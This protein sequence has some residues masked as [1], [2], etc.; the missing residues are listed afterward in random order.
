MNI[1]LPQILLTCLFVICSMSCTKGQTPIQVAGTATKTAVQ[2]GNWNDPATWGG[3]LPG[4][5]A[6][7]L[8]PSGITI[9]VNS[10]ISE[11]MKSIRIANGA[12]LQYATS[13]NT[14]LRTEYLVSEMGG[15]FEIGTASNKIAPN[16]KARLVFAE[17]GGTTQAEDP[18]R[19]APG[20]VLM[21][22]VR[23][24]GA[25][26]TNWLA[27]NNANQPSQ[28]AT[29]LVL[30]SAP[31]GWQV[32]DK[33]ALAG[34]D[35]NSFTSDEVVEI[36]GISGNV[37][38]IKS[39]LQLDHKAP[40][41]AS[42]LD[43]H[44]ANISRNIVVT[45]ENPSVT[46]ISGDFRKPRG[47]MMFMHNQD[48]DL[49]YV[50]ANNTGR[51]D[52]S[53]ILDDWD[54]EDLSRGR[55]TGN[56]IANGGRNPRGRYSFHF[57]RGAVDTSVYPAKAFLP[58]PAHVEGCVVNNDPGWG[59][60][61]HSSRVN[62]VRNVSYDVIGS[63]FCTESGN[64]TGSFIENIAIR[65]Y[66]PAEPMTAIPRPRN[67]YFDG[68]PTQALADIR[69][70]RQDFAWQGD[71]FWF[72]GTGVTVEGNVVAGST[73]H[74]YVYWVDGLIEKG[75]GMARGDIDTHVPA[76]E[77]PVLNQALKDWKAQYPGFVLDIWYL[78]PRP[79]KNNTAYTFARGVHTYYVHT[80]FHL[81][82]E[83][84]NDPEEWMN[85]TPDIYRKQL[86][87]VFD[88]TILWNIRRRGFG[89]NHT[90]NVTIQNSRVVGYNA[91]GEFENYGTNP[92]PGVIAEEPVAIGMDLDFYHNTYNWTL[93]NNTIEG[94]SG[95]AVG[96]TT[97]LNG[98]VIIDGGTFNNSGTDIEIKNPTHEPNE[99]FPLVFDGNP[100]VTIKEEAGPIRFLNENK[101]IVLLPQLHNH[102]FD[103][104]GFA[105][106]AD[107]KEGD[108]YF[109]PHELTFN[110]GPFINSRVYYNAQDSDFIPITS[111]TQCTLG[112][113]S[114]D[115]IPNRFVGKTNTQL[116]SQNNGKSFA[117]SITPDNA[118]PHTQIVG[119]KATGVTI[120]GCPLDN[121]QTNNFN[122]VVNNETCK[123]RSNGE[124]LITS[125]N[126]EVY[127]VNIGGSTH[128][129]SKEFK[130]GN[131]A[132]GTHMLCIGVRGTKKTCEWCYEV[133]IIEGTL[134]TGKSSLKVKQ[135]QSKMLV[136]I[137]EGTSPFKVKVN[138]KEAGSYTNSTF[139]IFVADKDKVE[140]TSNKSCEGKL[141][142]TA[143]LSETMEL[144]PN[145][146]KDSFSVVTLEPN[147]EEVYIQIY[148]M[149]G[150]VI[151]QGK[152]E[153]FDK[154][155]EVSVDQLA[156]GTYLVK[157]YTKGTNKIF[158]M[159]KQ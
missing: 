39:P 136:D 92:L 144:F 8:I 65:T 106:L 119:G 130:I 127:Y 67:S 110:F 135:N 56:P 9:T 47:H 70:G 124:I 44:I 20:A 120:D 90:S 38:N 74:A 75:L 11:E 16:V 157:V 154:R 139:E 52:K 73:G 98:K 147:V 82:K 89:H 152:Y 146:V 15:A 101:N 134:L 115:C 41:Q 26:K 103:Q 128:A 42:D 79:F 86:N 95:N 109:T 111:E 6:R 151:I 54:F 83:E 37:I 13:V 34:T 51:T 84:S 121:L 99:D 116:S 105:L 23:M 96:L 76:N 113:G 77:F 102:I 62:F 107:A 87:L 132:P 18:E 148:N 118:I 50:E 85:L 3:S 57:H 22:P 143:K 21:G 61:N 140:V 59:F 100:G 158:E 63:A 4:N 81:S 28:G 66:N 53:I 108:W 43:V 138:D 64:E 68:G 150:Q 156:E 49:R 104:D 36:T 33:L 112:G 10:M 122:I 60:V 91:S 88:N 141:Q 48:V 94:F 145:P 159:V 155:A 149:N 133:A 131:L 78:Q 25:E 129:F 7:V 27:F 117:G 114:I 19:F 45:S 125:Q 24:H 126:S 93:I 32:G 30:N 17:R 40:S 29:S 142:F 1:K 31:S 80:E 2:S 69:E 12:K 14:E 71:G 97:P 137:G 123:G 46:S 55:N 35:I 72:H 58:N 153:L 5:D